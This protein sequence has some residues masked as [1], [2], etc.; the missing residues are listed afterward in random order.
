[1]EYQL[2]IKST[3]LT[4][5]TLGPYVEH[6]W[7]RNPR[8][9]EAPQ[10]SNSTEWRVTLNPTPYTLHP[11]PY[12]LHPTPYTL[13]PTPYTLHPTPYTRHPTPHTLHPTPLPRPAPELVSQRPFSMARRHGPHLRVKTAL[14]RFTET[15]ESLYRGSCESYSG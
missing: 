13:H 4:Q 6:I 2:V 14:S 9:S 12:T 11:T 5:L 3:C 15:A 10:P 7:S 8:I 1:M